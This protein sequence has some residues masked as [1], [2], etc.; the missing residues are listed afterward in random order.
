MLQRFKK[1]SSAFMRALQTALQYSVVALIGAGIIGV[2]LFLILISLG[3]DARAMV[4]PIRCSLGV[5]TPESACFQAHLRKLQARLAEERETRLAAER[6]DLLSKTR[7]RDERDRRDREARIE[8]RRREAEARRLEAVKP[9]WLKRTAEIATTPPSTFVGPAKIGIWWSCSNCDVDLYA[10]NQHDGWLY[11]G[12]TESPDGKYH[13]D[14]HSSPGDQLEYID[15]VSADIRRLQVKV[16]MYSGRGD[17]PP[18]FKASGEVRLFYQDQ[19]YALPFTVSSIPAENN[20]EQ[21]IDVAR[22]LRLR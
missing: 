21:I 5:P 12:G 13:K 6:E 20:R 2:S 10:K 22:L 7:L 17:N 11:F 19:T 15:L 3:Y 9:V 8:Q 4:A 18:P 1:I 16:R 14:H